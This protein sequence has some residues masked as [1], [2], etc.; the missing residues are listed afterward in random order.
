MCNVFSYYLT[1]TSARFTRDTDLTT[2]V[3]LGR[4]NLAYAGFAEKRPALS[5]RNRL[6]KDNLD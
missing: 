3:F 4:F 2:I 1:G 6:K 5:R